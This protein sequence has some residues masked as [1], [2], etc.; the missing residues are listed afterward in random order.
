MKLAL[1]TDTHA[2]IRDGNEIIRAHQRKFYED[3]FFPELEDRGIYSIVH[4]GDFFDSRTALRHTTLSDAVWFLDNLR[5]RDMTMTILV[6]NHDTRNKNNNDDD[7]VTSVLGTHP[8]VITVS[9][10]KTFGEVL[11]IP[12]VN[13]NTL[14]GFIDSVQ[15]STAKYCFGHFDII[16]AKF[17]KYGQ[18][19]HEGF[20]P[21][22]FRK[23]DRVL[24]GHYHTKS[25][26]GNIDYLGSPF[27]YTWNDWND[28]KG[29]HI[30]DTDSNE[31]EF[32]ENPEELFVKIVHSDAGKK[33]IPMTED[34]TN[35]FVKVETTS[36][37][38]KSIA[39]VLDSVAGA[40][41]I[42]TSIITETEEISDIIVSSID[43]MIS[44]SVKSIRADRSEGVRKILE[45]AFQQVRTND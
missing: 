30:F 1:I 27:Q 19:A 38:K 42:Q 15:K 40:G 6:G 36:T 17:S 24:S 4:L 13:R 16:G 7:A 10:N 39:K 26:L 35:K 20:D 29:F 23:F 25:T 22:I 37:D 31:L 8:N 34:F 32:I 45:S 41:D 12:W 44:D 18:A 33:T 14:Q 2:G 9:E 3:V 43:T 5:K 28:N 11:Y 21:A